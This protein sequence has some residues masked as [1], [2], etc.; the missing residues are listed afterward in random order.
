[1]I[2]IAMLRSLLGILFALLAPHF[3]HAATLIQQ[4]AGSFAFEA[5][6]YSTLTGSNWSTISTTTG[7]QTLPNG[8]DAVGDAIFTRGGNLNSFATYD[9][10]F[11]QDGTYYLYTRYS[12]YD[13]VVN[14]AASYGNED[15]FFLAR[16]FGIAAAAG[17]GA[18][19][20]WLNQGLSN[21]GHRPANHANPNPNEGKFF[22]WDEA[23]LSGSSTEILT[24]IVSGASEDNPLNLSFTISNRETGVAIDRFVFSTTRLNGSISG[25]RSATLDGIASVPEPSRA[26]LCLF[27]LGLLLTRRR[28]NL[29]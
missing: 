16:D 28:A 7:I 6:D 15:S 23:T 22:Y 25:G 2:N 27:G 19:N 18:D 13:L 8:T 26:V 24:Y 3:S 14:D 29:N 21:H 4:N 5:E 20:D 10:Q 12:M 17:A 9:L 11:T 1:M